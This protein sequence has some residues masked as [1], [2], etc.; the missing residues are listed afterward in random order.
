[1]GKSLYDVSAAARAIFEVAGEKVT[2]DCFE[3]SQ[4]E[5]DMTDVT[6]PA[7]YT[8]DLAA[9]VA[10]AERVGLS[11]PN[12]AGVDDVGV[13][14]AAG[15]GADSASAVDGAPRAAGLG[16]DSASVADGAPRAAGFASSVIVEIIG[17]AGYSLGEY[18]AF[19]ASGIIPD[20]KA[21]IELIKERGRLMA[22]AGRH[23]DG[24]PRGAMA[25]VLGARDDVLELVERA[26]GRF[27]LEAVNLNTP[28]QTVISGDAEA[29]EAFRSLAKTSGKKLRVMP[30]SV[31][32]AFHSPIMAPASDGIREAASQIAFGEPVYELYLDMTAGTLTE[33]LKDKGEISGKAKDLVPAIMAEQVKSPVR[34]QEITEAFAAAGA[35]AIVEF[36]PGKTLTGFAKRTAPGVMALNVQ[37]AESLDETIRALYGSGE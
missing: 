27:V 21:G 1:M 12:E 23:A 13:S 2:R 5:L 15:F 37:D 20:V 30:L 10:F 36:G 6:Q 28:T 24:S 35:D 19:T 31:S 9:W 34:W 25:A 16:A 33:Y 18:S 8:V 7:V 32:T 17:M 11:W 29:I 4:E 26:R 14:G 22:A 3:A